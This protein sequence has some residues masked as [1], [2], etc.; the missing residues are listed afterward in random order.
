MRTMKVAYLLYTYPAISQS[1][2]LREVRE[3]RKLG[4]QVEPVS[5]HRPNAEDLLAAA[6][7]EEAAR[8]E[9]LLPPRPLALAAAHLRAA[10]GHPRVYLRS[11]IGALKRGLDGKTSLREELGYFVFAVFLWQRLAGR[12]IRHVHTHFAGAPMLMAR[13]V[14]ELGN[15]AAA[16]S[17]AWTWSVTI[18]G[19]VEFFDVSR[20][21]LELVREASF[22]AYVSEFARRQLL[23]FL[24]EKDWPKLQLVRCGLDVEDFRP[25]PP[26]EANGAPVELL[27]VGRQVAV[28]SPAT[29]IRAIAELRRR[30]REVSL[31][32]VGHGPLAEELR[33]LATELGVAEHIEFTG[34]VGQDDIRRYYERA[35][36]FC[37]S[38]AAESL[39]VVLMEAMA[40]AIPVVSTDVGG[41]AELV[42]HGRTGYLVRPGDSEAF[43]DALEPLLEDPGRRSEMG[44]SGRR[45]VEQEFEI[46]A[47]GRTLGA[48]LRSI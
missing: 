13:L 38:S 21:R 41:I 35:D 47:A 23:P 25:S 8:T 9:S 19:P 10:A 42:E 4:L 17:G 5:I 27:T 32:M 40:C 6:D 7:R 12:G 30:G 28:K 45:R 29:M 22:V 46:A 31:T 15:A 26:V 1:F 34:A 37:L 36:V 3:L 20:Y 43:A 14:A 11:L 24:E 39:P 2:I 16:E 44:R 48:L 33:A 18:H